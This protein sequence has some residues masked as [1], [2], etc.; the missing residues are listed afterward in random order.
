MTNPTS[1]S[2]EYELPSGLDQ[3]ALEDRLEGGFDRL[4][5]E[6]SEDPTLD[7]TPNRQHIAD[8]IEKPFAQLNNSTTPSGPPDEFDDEH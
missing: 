2:G 7:L 6:A 5:R 1:D 4:E 8:K 3:P